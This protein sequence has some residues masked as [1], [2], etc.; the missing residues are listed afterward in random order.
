MNSMS[1]QNFFVYHEPGNAH[2][3]RTVALL[4]ADGTVVRHVPIARE[5]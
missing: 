4:K 1:R 5:L 2:D 3:I